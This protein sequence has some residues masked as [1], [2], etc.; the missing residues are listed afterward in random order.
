[1]INGTTFSVGG[2]NIIYQNTAGS[3]NGDISVTWGSTATCYNLVT[4]CAG[5]PFGCITGNPI[6]GSYGSIGGST[7]LYPLGAGSMALNAG[8]GPEPT[9]PYDGSDQRGAPRPTFG[10]GYDMGSYQH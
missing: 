8:H 3:G 6:L 9:N 7:K 2:D 1:M 4:S 5:Q 10:A